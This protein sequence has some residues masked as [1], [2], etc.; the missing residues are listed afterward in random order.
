MSR[1]GRY[2]PP[3]ALMGL[4]FFLSA[5]P[6]LNS[7][8]GVADLVGRKLL[9]AAEYA[10]LWWL[11]LRALRYERPVPAAA[12]ALAYAATDELHQHFVDGRVA[13]PLDWLIDASGV[14][15]AWLLWRRWRGRLDPAALG[16]DQDRLGTVDRSELPVDVVEVG[17]DRAGGQ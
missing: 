12:I 5:Q 17:A 15:A 13:S 3:L 6:D 4:I 10:L 7:G 16:G 2:A 8:L 11:W 9:H 14:A 1:I